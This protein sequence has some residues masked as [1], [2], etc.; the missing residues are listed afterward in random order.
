[1]RPLLLALAALLATGN[2]TA[3]TLERRGAL[4]IAGGE[5]GNDLVRFEQALAGGG[6]STVV[7][8]QSP[9]GDLWTA[10]RI[11]RLI[12]D[13]GLRTVVAGRCLSACAIMFIGGRERRVAAGLAPGEAWLGLHGGHNRDTRQVDPQLQPQ[14]YA[15][16][17]QQLGERFDAAVMNRALYDMADA[18]AMLVVPV[19]PGGRAKPV[20]HCPTAQRTPERC[21]VLPELDAL[22]LGLLTDATPFAIE[23][24]PTRP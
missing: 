4:L 23:P 1:M 6:V 15:F 13:R 7:F 21:Q 9:G 19:P 22:R 12:A 17:R 16:F 11:G 18:Q 2:A 5:V 8:T 20:M 3:L 10:I 14:I 24:L